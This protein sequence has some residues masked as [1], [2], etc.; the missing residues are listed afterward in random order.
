MS[1]KINCK[2]GHLPE[3]ESE[4]Y[5]WDK[6]CVELVGP[7]TTRHKGRYKPDPKLWAVTM[8]NN[9]TGWFEIATYDDKK[10]M[11]IANNV[12]FTWIFHYP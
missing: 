11:T 8:I 1:K 12:E 4:T 2:F 9:T 5:T 7:Y 6:L 3:K 10:S